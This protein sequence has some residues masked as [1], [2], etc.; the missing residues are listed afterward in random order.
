MFYV[1][2]YKQGRRVLLSEHLNLDGWD[3]AYRKAA[4]VKGAVI[5]DMFGTVV[6]PE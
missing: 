4:N 5:S 1:Y 3:G 2:R 6:R